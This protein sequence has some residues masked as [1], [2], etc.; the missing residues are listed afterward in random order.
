MEAGFRAR[1][2]AVDAL[3]RSPGTRYVLVAAPRADAVAEASWF[4]ERLVAL[5]LTVDALVVNRAHPTFASASALRATTDDALAPWRENLAQLVAVADAE[6]RHVAEVSARVAPAPTVVVPMRA[7]D[8]HD[9]DGLRAL[10]A[11]LL[12]KLAADAVAGEGSRGRRARR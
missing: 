5:G 2:A 1:A 7:S 8:V 9:L 3:L 11:P 6:A 4:A 10:A 12:G